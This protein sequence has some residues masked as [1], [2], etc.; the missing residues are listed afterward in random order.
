VSRPSNPSLGAYVRSGN[1][2]AGLLTEPVATDLFGTE[3]RYYTT[4]G[5]RVYTS[6]SVRALARLL[7]RVTLN[8]LALAELLSFGLVLR[9]ETVVREIR[10]IP[11]HSV[12]NPDGT[13]TSRPGPHSSSCVAD[14]PTAAR[15]LRQLLDGIIDELEDQWG[16][17][18]VGFTGGKDSRILAALPKHS[19]D[20]W[21]YL[22]VSGRDDAE[23]Q[24]SMATAKRLKLEH[25]SWMEW[26]DQFLE[27]AAYRVSADLANGVGAVS[28]YTMLR[29]YF[30]GY[31]DRVL[32]VGEADAGV[33]LWIGALA[34]GLFAGTYLSSPANTIREALTP[35]TAHLPHVLTR[36]V[37]ERF[38][39]QSAFYDSNPFAFTA[40]RNEEVGYF[41]RLFTRGRCYICRTLAC[42]DRVGAA[43]VNPYLHPDVVALALE[44]DSRLFVPD[45][46][47]NGV[48][49]EFGPGLDEKSA[50]GYR[51]PGY[52][53]HVFRALSEEVRRAD[54]LSNLV[55]P[56]LLEQMRAGRFPDLS[57]NPDAATPSPAAPA[58]RV[59]AD[60]H[61]PGMRSLR[62]YEHLLTYATFLN[63]L[64]ED[65]VAV[66]G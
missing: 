42:F 5:G 35:R 7:G 50:F 18:C 55:D 26:T 33:A 40:E 47:R 46:L 38:Q 44:T 24:G 17:H 58:Y 51:A 2:S 30:E 13:I 49:A 31:R 14:G 48:L 52:G 53:H 8:E 43:Q 39:G 12:L 10:S 16:T 36:P 9:D 64:V 56:S 6:S 27:G 41:I 54:A 37:L 4:V 34:D 20:R 21:H 32:G 57:P 45:S 19:P 25:F 62:D 23:H 63:L 60:Q 1:R 22:S 28:D 61:Q 15:R 66:S 11:A 59:H 29:S 3:F 65:G